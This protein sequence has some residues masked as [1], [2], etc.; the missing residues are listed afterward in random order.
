TRILAPII[1]R[2]AYRTL[3]KEETRL[4]QGWTYEPHCFY[5]KNAA[6]KALEA[7]EAQR[8]KAGPRKQPCYMDEPSPVCD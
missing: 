2:V 3:K 6:A 1:G 4:A 8:T 7:T 5:E